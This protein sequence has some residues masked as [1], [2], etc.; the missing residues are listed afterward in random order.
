MYNESE[1]FANMKVLFTH[2]G[3]HAWEAVYGESWEISA[4]NEIQGSVFSKCFF[5]FVK[6]KNY[7]KP[8]FIIS[9]ESKL[10][11]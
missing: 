9:S 4:V 3:G 6:P 7:I 11:S 1:R 5:H 2:T 8:L 10:M